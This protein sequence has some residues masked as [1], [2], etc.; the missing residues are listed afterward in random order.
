[1]KEKD[2]IYKCIWRQRPSN[3]HVLIPYIQTDLPLHSK[4][5]M[6]WTHEEG[7]PKYIDKNMVFSWTRCLST[8]LQ[9]SG[10]AEPNIPQKALSEKKNTDK[11]F[12]TSIPKAF[13]LKAH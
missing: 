11:L 10:C 1:M 3:V 8:W 12:L 6:Y 5:L 4:P 2:E 9:L 7:K 13:K